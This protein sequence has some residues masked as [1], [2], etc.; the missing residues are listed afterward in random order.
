MRTALDLGLPSAEGMYN[1][2][3]HRGEQSCQTQDQDHVGR[4]LC[5][6]R[7]LL[8]SLG[9]PGQD[10]THDSHD[11]EQ[12]AANGIQHIVRDRA[13]RLEPALE[14]AH[15]EQDPNTKGHT[16]SCHHC[17]EWNHVHQNVA[18][19]GD[20]TPAVQA[21]TPSADEEAV[22]SGEGLIHKHTTRSHPANI[23]SVGV[24]ASNAHA[25]LQ[26]VVPE[27]AQMLRGVGHDVRKCKQ[28]VWSLWM[29]FAQ[30]VRSCTLTGHHEHRHEQHPCAVQD[31]I[32]G[33]GLESS[34]PKQTCSLRDQ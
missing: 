7:R 20:E 5:G 10:E 6:G 11:H 28:S 25:H 16:E 18:K 24:E 29:S 13:P 19:H 14:Q 1:G 31:V 30:V 3:E 8:M 26:G 23:G 9:R 32:Q 21:R 2:N 33:H 12:P 4:A 22:A 27:E 34:G 15:E 17:H